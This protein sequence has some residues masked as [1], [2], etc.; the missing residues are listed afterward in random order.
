MTYRIVVATD[1]S[2]SSDYALRYA[3]TILARIPD[4][5]LHLT[6]VLVDPDPSRHLA[7][8][9]RRLSESL[10]RLREI[11]AATRGTPPPT[12]ERIE[13]D[14]V[15]HVRVA[16]NAARAIEQLALDVSADLVV[17]GTHQRRGIDRFILGSVA[18]DLLRSGRIALLVARPPVFEGMERSETIEPPKPGVNLHAQRYDLVVSSERITWSGRPSHIAGL[19]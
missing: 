15:Y 6:H 18:E 8:T 13:R 1:F 2:A 12:G 17:V 19:L 5:E 16:P 9:E 4:S 7:Q 10:G 14:V 11:V 3:L